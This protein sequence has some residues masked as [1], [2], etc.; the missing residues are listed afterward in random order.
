VG[1]K[2]GSYRSHSLPTYVGTFA[3]IG[4]PCRPLARPE[5][6][7]LPPIGVTF[8]GCFAPVGG[9]SFSPIGEEVFSYRLRLQT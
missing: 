2:S 8:S 1:Q 6:V 4:G 7:I 5:G 9:V 3:P